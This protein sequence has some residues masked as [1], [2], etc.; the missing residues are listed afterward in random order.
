M[1][2]LL[3][4][5]VVL[6]W[7]VDAEQIAGEAADAIERAEEVLVSAASV[8]EI[9]IKRAKGKLASPPDLRWQLAETG[10][11]ELKIS[12]EHA[13]E[14][15]RLPHLH[16]DPFDRMLIAQARIEG[17][18]LMTSDEEILRYQVGAFRVQP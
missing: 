15:A 1:R 5:H 12:G 16:N 2:L 9:E 11:R 13:E 14:A 3:D 18:T 7:L 8:W 17:V 10:F 6:W 4:T